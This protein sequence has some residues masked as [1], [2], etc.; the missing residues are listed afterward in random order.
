MR[1]MMNKAKLPK[2][3]GP[4]IRSLLVIN[5]AL[6]CILAVVTLAPAVAAQSRVRGD[7]AIVGGGANGSSS[8]LVYVIDA[9]NQEMI[10]AM[11][12]TSNKKLDGI[13]YRN[14][15]GDARSVMRSQT[16]GR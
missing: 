15:A 8:S 12:D 1:L 4:S 9:V 6:L 5:A 14:L 11:Y 2:R 13:G 3:A 10:V 16:P 7:Y